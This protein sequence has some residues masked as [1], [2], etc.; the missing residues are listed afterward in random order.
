MAERALRLSGRWWS[1][2]RARR[3]AALATGALAAALALSGGP[4][5][6]ARAQEAP[7]GTAAPDDAPAP[8]AEASPSGATGTPAPVAAGPAEAAGAGA[9]APAV[10]IEKAA[11]AGDESRR[12]T[13][14]LR[15]A[16]LGDVL[17][18][19]AEL[20]ELNIITPKDIAGT[21]TMRF[22][23]VPVEDALES[24]VRVNGY[25]ILRR[26]AILEVIAADKV[27][28]S[29]SKDAM[30]QL[31]GMTETAQAAGIGASEIR[32]FDVKY[33]R[34]EELSKNIIEP[35]LTPKVG[36][37][38]Y[39]ATRAKLLVRD[40]PENVA[41]IAQV[42]E[43]L[44]I[45]AA[46]G[47]LAGTSQQPAAIKVVKL[48]YI[49]TAAVKKVVEKVAKTE[50]VEW[51][52]EVT[53]KSIILRGF[54]ERIAAVE[55]MLQTLD[56][57][58]QQ[59]RISVKI[60]ETSLG[61]NEKLGLNWT[62]RMRANG[63]ARPWTFPFDS[64]APASWVFYPTPNPTS[65]VGLGGG[66]GGTGQQLL[67]GFAPGDSMPQSLSSQFTFG[68]LDA[69][70]LSVL[71][72]AI[73]SDSNSKLLASPSLTTIDNKKAKIN[74]GQI[75]PIPIYTNLVNTQTNV[76]FPTITGYEDLEVGTILTVTP[77]IGADRYVTMDVA[78]EISEI[79]GYVGP[80]QERPIR[81]QR[82][83]ET[84][85]VLR[86]GTTLVL[87]GLNQSR[88]TDTV[89]KVP[90]LGDIPLL[91]WFFTWRS[92]DIQ[93]TDLLIFITPEIVEE[94]KAAEKPE[95]EVAREKGLVKIDD[96][97]VAASLVETV[98]RTATRLRSDRP[99]T[100]RAAIAEVAGFEDAERQG[101][102]VRTDFLANV[103]RSDPDLDVK[104]TAAETLGA[105]DPKRLSQELATLPGNTPIQAVGEVLVPAALRSPSRSVRQL[106][107]SSAIK[108][109]RASTVTALMAAV[110]FGRPFERVVGCE[111]L[112]FAGDPAAVPVLEEA[113]LEA[114]PWLAPLA[115]DAIGACGGPQAVKALL[116]AL[117]RKPEPR[118]E[119]HIA[120]A[121]TEA[122]A[123]D[124]KLQKELQSR[125]LAFSPR[126]RE[127]LPLEKRDRRARHDRI[128]KTY[129]AMETPAGP[130]VTG[131]AEAALRVKDA[132]RML[133]DGAPGHRHLVAVALRGIDVVP[134]P[135]AAAGAGG[136]D[137]GVAGA[138]AGGR[139]AAQ[140]PIEKVEAGR[141]KLSQL[142]VDATP[143]V[144]LAHQIV[145]HAA[146]ADALLPP[147]DARPSE[148]PAA[149][150]VTVS[151][152][153]FR[154]E[155]AA[156]REQFLTIQAL[157]GRHDF[158][159]SDGAAAS[160]DEAL[161]A[162]DLWPA[163]R[164]QGR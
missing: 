143:A 148:K 42:I 159:E 151:V 80:F 144:H 45:P 31:S 48:R 130:E 150:A 64:H 66:G 25:A 34:G 83:M 155:E 74:L 87:G 44:D 85:V 133:L 108:V 113:L 19:L 22:K 72:E 96:R 132:L 7:T 126:V 112:A 116:D 119:M 10:A 41:K 124:A 47:A 68:V 27:P 142:E 58:T 129:A 76:S 121:L 28:I 57:R 51:E 161:K 123:D 70:Q 103:M 117:A 5:P 99:E 2:F 23:D 30:R 109:D 39:D 11:A 55:R 49:E 15:Q 43:K 163:P 101:L 77:R 154:L 73:Q 50:N 71:F 100:R 52:E 147:V 33:A 91:G 156:L 136:K 81:S 135:S 127:L 158:R 122:I 89:N 131:P 138:S 3:R 82:R 90:Y 141:L 75:V 95:A 29:A 53:T 46:E 115:A 65:T 38:A 36:Y 67:A 98:N 111:G 160:I 13:L 84:S 93:K 4:A 153:G 24:I 146:L 137:G 88:T 149:S 20:Y 78:P 164:P 92:N 118:L 97:W 140:R 21:V 56:Q 12:V 35:M 26:G 134:S 60:I 16:P 61:N 139:A 59:V 9:G 54:P 40:L 157:A 62:M 105:I 86:S 1:A 107:L 79:T 114:A 152:A 102:L 120:A 104:R 110:A 94:E 125:G 14:N 128:L 18:Q 69:S 106:V 8:A 63:S 6:H 162:R 37:V 32:L 17:R 145:Y